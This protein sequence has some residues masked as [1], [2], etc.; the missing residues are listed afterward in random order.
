MLFNQNGI[1]GLSFLRKNIFTTVLMDDI[2]HQLHQYHIMELVLPSFSI[3]QIK[4]KMR[5]K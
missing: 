4:G 5:E 2:N 3:R 1:V